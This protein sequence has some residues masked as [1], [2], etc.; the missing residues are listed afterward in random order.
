MSDDDRA[1]LE[2]LRAAAIAALT[3][4]RAERD[5]PT[6]TRSVVTE[7]NLAT[8]AALVGVGWST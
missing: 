5:A 6:L 2:R 8:L 7:H 4:L 3:A 1:E